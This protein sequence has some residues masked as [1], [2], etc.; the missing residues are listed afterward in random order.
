[1][2]NF[3][4]ILLC[5]GLGMLLRQ[6]KTVPENAHQ[7]L[8]TFV[9]YISLPAISLLY[10][11]QLNIT[12]E[13]LYPFLMGWIVL[14]LSLA[15][16]TLLQPLLK[17]DRATLGCLI[18]VCGLGNISFVGF[19]IMEA[20]YGQ[21]GLEIAIFVDQG[22]FLALSLLGVSLAM[23][24]SS[25]K[26]KAQLITQ[27]ILYF[28]PFI[29]FVLALLLTAFSVEL[30]EG[31]KKVL[32]TLGNTLTP[33]ALTSVGLQLSFKFKELK[34]K[35]LFWGL[36]YKLLLAPAVIYLLYFILLNE[37]GLVGQVSIIEA[38]MPPMVTASIIATQYN[39]NPPLANFLVGAGLI[40]S[41][42]LIYGWYLL[43]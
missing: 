29:A 2:S 26:V 1:M 11:P 42:P 17:L 7:G 25:G 32:S 37:T 34:L 6:I 12:F 8:N 31:F 14:G 27:K 33:L 15:F 23:I 30:S 43:L 40:I 9:I 4:L 35:A 41:L 36:S 21:E 3:I 38:A 24:Y 20:F 13:V 39:L 16:F 28:P 10:I 5:L 19:P 18:I 22:C